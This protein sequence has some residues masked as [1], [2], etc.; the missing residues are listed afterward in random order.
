MSSI[1]SII[2]LSLSPVITT[3]INFVILTAGSNCW[4]ARMRLSST[5]WILVTRAR[6]DACSCDVGVRSVFRF[7]KAWKGRIEQ[8]HQY[9]QYSS[10]L[11]Y[12]FWKTNWIYCTTELLT[13]LLVLPTKREKNA[14]L[15]ILSN[16]CSTIKCS[17]TLCILLRKKNH[18]M[19][20]NSIGH[21]LSQLTKYMGPTKIVSVK[22]VGLVV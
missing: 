16:L 2:A 11:L 3:V 15:L 9:R 12:S 8:C 18:M 6:I 19:G 7:S 1:P 14:H 17:S 20:R 5:P 21:R 22:L 13:A 4:G 10:T